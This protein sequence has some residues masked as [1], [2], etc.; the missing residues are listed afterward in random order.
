MAT[1]TEKPEKQEK[2]EENAEMFSFLLGSDDEG[3]KT[4]TVGI[5]GDIDEEGAATMVYSLLTL[6]ESIC[7][8]QIKESEEKKQEEEKPIKMIISTHGG[9]AHE[10]FAIYDVMRMIKQECDI[11]TV[12]LGKVMSAGVVLLSAGTK[13]KRKV[14]RNCRIMIHPVNAASYGDLKDIENET[15][16][17]KL[18]QKMYIQALSDNTNMKNTQIKRLLKKKVNIYLSAEEAVRYG[19]V[20][21]II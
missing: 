12:G 13:G 1:P 14:G 8:E 18:L 10:M 21:E 3:A 15:K 5:Y 19:I 16:E 4:R 2:Q 7:K 17:L 11:E 9:S 20:D 6:K